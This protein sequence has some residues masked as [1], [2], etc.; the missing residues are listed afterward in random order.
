MENGGPREGQSRIHAWSG[1]PP[2]TN[3][4]LM[5]RGISPPYATTSQTH[6]TSMAGDALYNFGAHKKWQAD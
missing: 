4:H 5:R 6:W 3:E 1:K 2:A